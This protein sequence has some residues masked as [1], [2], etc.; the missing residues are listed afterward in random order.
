MYSIHLN[1]PFFGSDFPSF[2][3][4]LIIRTELIF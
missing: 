4:T 1:G 3:L 2:S